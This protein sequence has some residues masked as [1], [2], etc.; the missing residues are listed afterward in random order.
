MKKK[1]KW[2]KGLNTPFFCVRFAVIVFMLLAATGVASA[3]D[4]YVA[5]G[6]N[7]SLDGQSIANAWQH[8]S[9]AAQQ[10]Q[11]GDTIFLL[12]GTWYDEEIIFA[13]SGNETNRITLTV[14]KEESNV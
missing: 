14:H 3:T 4:Y 10:V 12:D 13:N 11:A 1:I 8:P 2:K 7:N 5:T 9:Y 6:G